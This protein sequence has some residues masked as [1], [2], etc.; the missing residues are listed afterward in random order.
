MR[1][2]QKAL[3]SLSVLALLLC[4]PA[5][6]P[7]KPSAGEGGKQA[8]A[9]VA[10]HSAGQE[11]ASGSPGGENLETRE[12]LTEQQKAMV[13]ARVGETVITLG[14]VEH[15]LQKQPSFARSRYR[16]FDKKVEF[17][18]NLIQFELL[19]LEARK[20][21]YDSDPD[22][23]L[24]MKRALVQKYMATDLQKLVTVSTIEEEEVKRYYDNNRSM[25]QKPAQVRASHILFDD[26][27]AAKKALEEI[28]AAI[29]ADKPRARVIFSDFARRLSRDR[30]TS[31]LNGDLNFFTLDGYLEE[32]RSSKIRLPKEVV[33]GAFGL[34]G[35]N[36]VSDVVRSE[37]GFHL[38]QVTNR[39]PALNRSLE[40]AK[41][42]ITSILLRER[43]DAAREAHIENL[44]HSAK[45]TVNPQLLEKIR[46]KANP[47]EEHG[48]TTTG[49]LGN[50]AAHVHT[51]QPPTPPA[52]VPGPKG[53]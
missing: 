5:C 7:D 52:R 2:S 12:G 20:K 51:P 27:P 41:R 37:Q 34:V 40:D 29:A 15:Q 38:V 3:L 17:L 9:R 23:V 42:Q 28:Q 6:R 35:L 30:A 4:V 33:N 26:E 47:G 36:Q 16:T 22:V 18:N 45:V 1:D 48:A 53:H 8:R 14:D 46:L 39:R 10:Q 21:G 32:E 43:K 31:H 19:V 44:R 24:A 25:F 50:P 49:P 11:E 13:V